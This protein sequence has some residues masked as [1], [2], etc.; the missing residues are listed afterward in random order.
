MSTA[1]RYHYLY[2]FHHVELDDTWTGVHSGWRA[3]IAELLGT[4][5]YTFVSCGVTIATNTMAVAQPIHSLLVI[6]LGNG[7]AFTSLAF[8]FY[9]LSG[10]L[11]NPATTWGAL[12]TRRIG[13]M[14]GLAYMIAQVLGSMLG[15][16]LASAAT[17]AE[18]HSTMSGVFWEESL[19]N[20]SGFLLEAMLTFF[21][22]FVVFAT[23]FDPVGLGK[24]APLPI[25]LTVS[26]GYFIGWVFVGPPM[27]P[28]R[29]LGS[30]V[31]FGTY[32]HMWVYWAGPFAGATV[33]ALLYTLLFISRPIAAREEVVKTST[34][35]TP[36]VLPTESSRLINSHTIG[37][38]AV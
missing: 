35:S 38:A 10:G 33:A 16:L 30:A 12:I 27:N 13:V 7:L 23:Y 1:Y 36:G 15:A 28:A 5:L 11:L 34:Y 21:L 31:V 20:F 26:F 18:F 14:R 3:I 19:S 4:L 25:G 2:P 6:A 32:D 17:P 9:Q 22:V 37:Q 8:A 29:A 24:L